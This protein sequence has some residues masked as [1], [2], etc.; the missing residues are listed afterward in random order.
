[1]TDKSTKSWNMHRMERWNDAPGFK[2]WLKKE[3]RRAARRRGRNEAD[4]QAAEVSR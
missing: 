4:L 3:R 1:M 2:R